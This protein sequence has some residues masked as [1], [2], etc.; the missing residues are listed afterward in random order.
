MEGGTL[1]YGD[2]SLSTPSNYYFIFINGTSSSMTFSDIEIK[3]ISGMNSLV[4]IF[5]GKVILNYLKMD[6]QPDTMWVNQL[7]HVYPNKSAVTV[8]L[9]CCK[10]TN[11]KYKC[12]AR[13]ESCKSAV[14]Y[15]DNITTFGTAITLNITLCFFK[16]NTFNINTGG[17]SWGG[18][19]LF[20]STAT[21]SGL[22][23]FILFFIFL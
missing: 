22:F 3:F 1:H 15:F 16:N 18:V 17:N 11:C 14:I 13:E 9:Y 19:F 21:S 2:N 5:G 10:I 12:M 4:Y 20:F 6:N 23:L 7:I 8:E